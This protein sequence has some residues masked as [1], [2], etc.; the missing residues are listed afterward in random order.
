[1][2]AKELRIGNYVLFENYPELI[3]ESYYLR[4]PLLIHL[5]PIPLTEEWLL[6]IGFELRNGYTHK[7]DGYKVYYLDISSTCRINCDSFNNYEYAEFR[8]FKFKYVHQL[9]NL[10]FAITGE[11][12]IK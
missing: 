1:M 4:P 12:L 9:Q 5:D 6:K 7:T 3:K 2:D 8:G 11:E 10:Y